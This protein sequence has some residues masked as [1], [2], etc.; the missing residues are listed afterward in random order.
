MK[1]YKVF[2]NGVYVGSAD[3]TPAEVSK[4]NNDNSIILSRNQAYAQS[5]QDDNLHTDDDK[6][7]FKKIILH[8]CVKQEK[9]LL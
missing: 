7:H 9:E 4:L 5:M 3:L 2:V 6:P 8:L 1:K